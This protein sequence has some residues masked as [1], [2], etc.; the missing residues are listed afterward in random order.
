MSDLLLLWKLGTMNGRWIIFSIFTVCWFLLSSS[1]CLAVDTKQIDICSRKKLLDS[2]DLQVIDDFVAEAVKELTETKD[3]TSIAKIR[4]VILSRSSSSEESA[5]AQYGAQFSESAYKYISKA[6]ETANKLTPENNRFRII[7]NLLILVDSLEDLR[8]ADLAIGRLND[9]NSAIQYWA[10]H[11]IT[12]AGITKQLNA[13]VAVNAGLA[14][15][16]TE[17]LKGLVDS[18]SPE[19]LTLIAEFAS[20]LEIPQGEE[21]LLQIANTRIKRYADWTVKYELL[22][23]NILKLLDG[24]IPPESMSKPEIGRRFG[25]LYSYAIQR[26]VNGQNVLS[27]T[28]TNQLAS[29]LVE[30]EASCISKR[31]KVTQSVIKNAIEKNDYTALMQEHDRLLGDET[32]AGQ[33]SLKLNFDYGKKP[34][35]NRRTAPLA[36]PEP[37]KELIS[38][39]ETETDIDNN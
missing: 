5:K 19:V 33:L 7:L 1:A 4:T 10:V 34:D 27:N 38:S 6:L 16:I 36:L 32:R 39:T 30:I 11:S 8:L 14:E 12:N 21:L 23:G 31:L 3:F 35:G 28:Q 20:K 17:Q 25:Q 18:S 37:P 9:K 15:K 2:E 24:K 26:Y 29:V 22:D 13:E